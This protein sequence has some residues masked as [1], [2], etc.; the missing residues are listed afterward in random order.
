ME[1][2][3]LTKWDNARQAVEEARSVDEL[4]DIRD[5]AEAFRLYAKQQ[6]QS[7]EVQNKVAEI[8]LRCEKRIGEMLQESIPHEGGRPKQSQD[9]TV[10]GKLQD[11]GITKSDSSRWQ[12]IATLPDEKFDEYVEEIKRSNEELT[13]VGMVRLAKQI[14][15]QDKIEELK[16][17]TITLPEGQYHTIVIDPPWDMKKIDRD[18][19]P[20]DTGF[21][22]PTM[23]IEEI[24]NMKIPSTDNCHLYLWTTEK[25]LPDAFDILKHW[26]FTYIF[27]MVWHKNGGYQPF[28]LPQYN[29]EFVLFGRKGNLP[30]LDTK[31]F[32]TCFN[33]PRREHSR[34]PN[35][36]YNLVERVSPPP[37]IDMFSREKRNGFDQMGNENDKF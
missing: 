34:K 26:G 18:N 1:N 27:T 9:A 4:K 15:N 28:N 20:Q 36:F 21:D 22:Y 31:D 29:C 32:F 10:I 35:E 5:R 37:R 30:F 23:S 12:A 8:K 24:K 2:T 25:Y 14:E 6:K 3:Q 16:N 19:S 11:I 13:T 33:A 7:L 17:N